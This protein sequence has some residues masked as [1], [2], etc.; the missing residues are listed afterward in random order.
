MLGMNRYPGQMV[1]IGSY[2]VK[3]LEVGTNS[4]H[5]GV[6]APREIPIDRYDA[7]GRKLNRGP[8][9]N[10]AS[11]TAQ[12]THESRPTDHELLSTKD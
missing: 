1:K 10:L 8:T 7:H 9:D 2:E 5:L 11:R 6:T 12:P 3:V 4:V